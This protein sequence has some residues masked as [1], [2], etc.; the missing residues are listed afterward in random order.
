MPNN[1]LDTIVSLTAIM[2]EETARLQAP[3]RHGD[4]AEMAAAKIKLVAELETE[5]AARERTGDDWLATL[6][7]EMRENLAAAVRDL[8]IAAAANARVLERQIDLSTEMMAAVAGE[9]RRV[10]G[11]RSSIYGARGRV[12]RSDAAAPISVNASL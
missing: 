12:A 3:G 5:A 10:T 1:Y 7:E 11:S 4:F 8:G 9:A 6:S 2:V